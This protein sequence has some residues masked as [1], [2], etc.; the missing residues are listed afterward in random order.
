ML[1]AS[2]SSASSAPREVV[3]LSG[4]LFGAVAIDRDTCGPDGVMWSWDKDPA[5]GGERPCLPPPTLLPAL[6]ESA[7]KVLQTTRG[8]GGAGGSADDFA[9]LQRALWL[10]HPL[11]LPLP[12][13][14]VITVP[15]EKL[16]DT[17][18]R[19]ITAH[20]DGGVP[21][22][23]ASAATS[24]SAASAG[25]A[26]SSAAAGGAGSGVTGPE[27]AT[28]AAATTALSHPIGSPSPSD[29]ASMSQLPGPWDIDAGAVDSTREVSDYDADTQAAIRRIVY[30]QSRGTPGHEIEAQLK[31]S[32]QERAAAAATELASARASTQ[33][34]AKVTAMAPALATAA[35]VP[36]P[37][38]GPASHR[39]PHLAPPAAAPV[40][41]SPSFSAEEIA[42]DP[43]LLWGT[44]GTAATSSPP[45]SDAESEPD[46]DGEGEGKGGPPGSK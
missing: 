24:A 29:L 8:G 10:P 22:S 35:A 28:A 34:T 20:P 1:P 38:S 13:G 40:P 32:E 45:D 17:W 2:S 6:P 9:L 26:A 30:E 31:A 3:L 5:A 33:T 14:G 11:P 44:G 46:S 42:R 23:L 36:A 7:A 27:G 12:G 43:S 16:E 21:G 15:L 39:M 41:A 37:V 25:S 18:W 19:R 4:P